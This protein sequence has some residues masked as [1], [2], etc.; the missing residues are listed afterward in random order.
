MNLSCVRN[1]LLLLVPSLAASHAFGA[2]T[3]ALQKSSPSPVPLGTS[4]TWT[5]V[6]SGASTGGLL[7]RYQIQGPSGALK[8]VV[9]YGPNASLTW[10]TIEQEGTYQMEVSVVNTVTFEEA[11]SWGECPSAP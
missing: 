10:T 6:V 8:T 2:M 5:A 11:W 4:V 3:V 1:R 7:Y 9:D